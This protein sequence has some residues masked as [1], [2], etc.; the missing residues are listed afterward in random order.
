M[1]KYCSYCA[2]WELSTGRH[3]QIRLPSHNILEINACDDRAIILMGTLSHRSEILSWH[4]ESDSVRSIYF[5][6]QPL[7][8]CWSKD[9]CTQHDILTIIRA[10]TGQQSDSYRFFRQTFAVADQAISTLDSRL[11][12]V[13]PNLDLDF[14]HFSTVARYNQFI[15]HYGTVVSQILP[16]RPQRSELAHE[17]VRDDI[18]ISYSTETDRLA[19]QPAIR[20]AHYVNPRQSKARMLTVDGVLYYPDM[21][22]S[23]VKV[24]HILLAKDVFYAHYNHNKIRQR[25]RAIDSDSV[26]FTFGDHRFYGLAHH[27][28]LDV[29]SFDPNTRFAPKNP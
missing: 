6:G 26:Y 28:G 22:E 19:V 20:K 1:S 7:F 27:D 14:R 5:D 3:H 13:V 11:L 9:E 8:M 15:C 4:L 18:F 10:E 16:T 2:A 25:G 17:R 21:S 24:N 12:L 29:W 23:A